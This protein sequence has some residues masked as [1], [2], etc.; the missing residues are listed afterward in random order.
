M[1]GKKTQE[2]E[3]ELQLAVVYQE[4]MAIASIVREILIMK[5]RLV[6]AI[7]VFKGKELTETQAEVARL[8]K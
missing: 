5:K 8:L 3:V 7:S 1:K 6:F 4:R 2:T